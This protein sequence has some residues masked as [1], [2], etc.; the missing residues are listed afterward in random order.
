MFKVIEVHVAVRS[1]A[2]ELLEIVA[3]PDGEV[4]RLKSEAPRGSAHPE[5][6]DCEIINFDNINLT[7][8]QLK[9]II[10]DQT[11]AFMS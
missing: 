10:M 9:L 5:V 2:G 3:E 6:V 8:Y 7:I 11:I 4:Q 1:V